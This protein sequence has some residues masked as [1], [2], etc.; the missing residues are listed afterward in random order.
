MIARFSR[1]LA[2]AAIFALVVASTL[3]APAAA[4]GQFRR[5][6]A[7]VK[8]SVV[9]VP[10]DLSGHWMMRL[11]PADKGLVE[12]WFEKTLPVDLIKVV[13]L[14]GS[15]TEAGMGDDVTVDTKWTGGIVDKSWFTAPEYAPY[16]KPG[17]I[18]VPFWLNPTK[19]YVGPAWYQRE[20]SVP[21]SWK[22]RRILLTLE[23]VHWETKVWVDGNEAGTC[24]S[25]STPHDYDLTRLGLPGRH[26][27][28][29]RVDNRIKEIDVGENAH[30]VSDHTQTNWNGIVGRI[31]LAAGSALYIDEVRVDPDVPGRKARVTVALVNATGR[32]HT[33]N[34]VLTA[35]RPNAPGTAPVAPLY[36]RFSA[37]EGRSETSVDYPLGPDAALWDEFSPSVYALTVSVRGLVAAIQ[38]DKTIRFG[39]REFKAQG[40][41]F[42]VNGRPVFLRG[43]LE[44]CIFPKTGYPPMT[45]DEWWR[46]CQV[47]KAHGLNHIR[48]H[49]WCPPEAA[50]DAAD[51]AGIY[52]YVE[53]P[54]WAEIGDGKPIDAWLY[55]ESERIVKAYGNHPSFCMMSYG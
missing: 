18:K 22:G 8:P 24:D 50:F 12:R 9:K 13:R 25:L 23:R 48:F 36:V 6:E 45:Q 16:R 4:A 2:S 37:A 11:D 41:R 54:L 44:C 55:K 33:G 27:L 17:S 47:A 26:R 1:C 5:A 30:S 53:C 14:P 15:L 21:K 3:T 34:M 51:E 19:H 42:L 35:S 49:S 29:I 40:T 43:T 32:V 20:I 52:L 39:L 10:G 7:P 28:L 46:I 31:T 38:D